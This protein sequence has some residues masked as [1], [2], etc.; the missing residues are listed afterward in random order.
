MHILFPHDGETTWTEVILY[1]NK[2]DCKQN[3]HFFNR[4]KNKK[5]Y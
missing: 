2:E 1:V 4:L 5:L 3:N